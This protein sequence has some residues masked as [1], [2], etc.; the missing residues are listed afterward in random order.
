MGRGSGHEG[1][2]R[3][4]VVGLEV[5]QRL[6]VGVS[7]LDESLL[8]EVRLELGVLHDFVEVVD[9]VAGEDEEQDAEH[10]GDPQQPSGEVRRIDPGEPDGH[11]E[12]EEHE[13]AEYEERDVSDGLVRATARSGET[14][15]R[16]GAA[17]L[18]HVLA[19]WG[20]WESTLL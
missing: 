12:P 20:I 14:V 2:V 18:F 1:V 9:E 4:P 15:V 16:C 7:L 13:R 19:S 6:R 17:F 8:D 5:V 10:R 3:E 11:R